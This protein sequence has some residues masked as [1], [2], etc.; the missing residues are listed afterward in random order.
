[1]IVLHFDEASRYLA[2]YYHLSKKLLPKTHFIDNSSDQEKQQVRNWQS[3]I[4][5][6]IALS[7]PRT[8]LTSGLES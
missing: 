7:V 1:M 6:S 8:L 2:Y 4:P 3:Q 5:V